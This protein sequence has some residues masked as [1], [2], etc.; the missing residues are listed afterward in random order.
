MINFNFELRNP[1][2]NRFDTLYYKDAEFENNKFGEIQVM[3][4]TN[5]VMFQVR[6]STRCDHAGMELGIGL[7]GYSVRIQYCNTRHWNYDEGRYYV[8]D[9]EGNA[10]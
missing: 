4:D 7:L 10:T 2:S 8:Y 1:F 6:F 9:N 5:I 3:K